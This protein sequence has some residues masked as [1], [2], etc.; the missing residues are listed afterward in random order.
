MRRR[1]L[2]ATVRCLVEHGYR[3]TTIARVTRMAGASVGAHQHH[4]PRKVEALTSAIEYLADER[5]AEVRRLAAAIDGAGGPSPEEILDLVW[6][7]LSG[8]LYIASRELAMAARSDEELR[9]A[10][11]DS[12]RRIGRAI[13]GLFHDLLSERPDVADADGALTMSMDAM[14]GLAVRR[15]LLTEGDL[16][17]IWA[18]YRPLILALLCT[19]ESAP[20]VG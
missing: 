7:A 10:L 8:E 15:V 19:P 1:L 2:E 4:F 16:A 9:A 14:R 3:G 18:S 12:E 17:A 5:I 11:H 20:A 13:R 6:R